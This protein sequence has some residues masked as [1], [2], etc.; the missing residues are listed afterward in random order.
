MP[1]PLLS[2]Y[3][4]PGSAPGRDLSDPGKRIHAAGRF[5]VAPEGVKL[6]APAHGAQIRRVDSPRRYAG[7]LELPAI[8]GRQVDVPSSLPSEP[9]RHLRAHLI[10]ALSDAGTDRRAQV[11]GARPEARGHGGHGTGSDARRAAAPTR[12]YRG[13]PAPALLPTQTENAS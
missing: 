5:L 4:A 10:T 1:S 8:G 6:L 13:H 7:F 9:R 2:M 3:R 12:V 11:F